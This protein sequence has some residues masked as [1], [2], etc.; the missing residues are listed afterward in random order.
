MPKGA[1][2]G[3]R[4]KGIGAA[5]LWRFRARNRPRSQIFVRAKSIAYV[6]PNAARP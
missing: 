2:E 4:R 1:H 3:N 6:V 5:N